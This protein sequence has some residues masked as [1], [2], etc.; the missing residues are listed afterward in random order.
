MTKIE[1]EVKNVEFRGEKYILLKDSLLKP[2]TFEK[3]ELALFI[4][5]DGKVWRHHIEVGDESEVLVLG[6]DTM[7]I[8]VVDLISAM[9]ATL[10][11]FLEEQAE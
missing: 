2:D 4:L 5:Q 11:G 8:D 3:G 1:A 9:F 6:D 7:T 10:D